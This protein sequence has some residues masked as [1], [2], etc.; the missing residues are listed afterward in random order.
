MYSIISLP[1]SLFIAFSQLL[2]WVWKN[3]MN[4]A[5]PLPYLPSFQKHKLFPY[6]CLR[7]I[8]QVYIACFHSLWLI[9]LIYT[10]N[11]KRPFIYKFWQIAMA[12]I[13]HQSTNLG[14]IS[15]LSIDKDLFVHGFLHNVMLWNT[16]WNHSA[17]LVNKYILIT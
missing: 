1:N 15:T 12:I 3:L 16:F 5:I 6:G 2:N 17:W 4:H 14:S 7:N 10:T 8:L 11:K 13:S 9:Q